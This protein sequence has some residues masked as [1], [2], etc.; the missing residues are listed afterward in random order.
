MVGKYRVI[1]LCGNE[2]VC[3]ICGEPTV[4]DIPTQVYLSDACCSS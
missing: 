3:P 1:T 2:S 4:E